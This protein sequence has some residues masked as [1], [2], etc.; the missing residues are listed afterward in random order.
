MSNQP[1]SEFI[2]V[3]RIVAPFGIKGDVKLLPQTDFP[4]RL[5]EHETLYL[6]DKHLPHR[7]VSA[8]LHGGV[9]LLHFAG[10]DD[11]TTAEKLR[12][13]TVFIPA[14]EVAP[15]ADDQ[16]YI[17]DLI[18]LRAVHANGTDLGTVADV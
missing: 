1:R 18:G 7:L 5:G 12:G 9:I 14:A 15:L 17:H 2:I 8:R 11:M 4:E 13:L 16:Y 3:G 10:I 6:G